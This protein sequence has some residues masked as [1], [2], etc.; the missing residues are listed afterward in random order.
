M[1]A[2]VFVKEVKPELKLKKKKGME[3]F[4]TSLLM[5]IFFPPFTEVY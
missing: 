4:T 3:E 1:F 2:I 5:E